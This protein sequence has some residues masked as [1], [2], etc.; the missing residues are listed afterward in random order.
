MTESGALVL[1]TTSFPLLGDGSEAA[2]SFVS[3][4]AEALAEHV[5]VRV[6]CPG[7]TNCRESWSDGVEVFRFAAPAAPMSSLVPWNP[8]DMYRIGRVLRAGQQAVDQAVD[9]GPTRQILALWALPS[10]FWARNTARRT[11]IPYS[12]WT[13]GSDVWSLGRLPLVRRVLRRVLRDA[14]RCY[15]DGFE[16]AEATRAIAGREVAFLP[17]TRNIVQERTEPLRNA[18]PYRLLY[19]GRWH[20]N[21]GIDI[22]LEALESLRDEDWTLIESVAIFGGGELDAQVHRRAA[23]LRVMGRPVNVG[24]YL[25]KAQAESALIGSDYLLIPSR[26]ESIPV[27]LSDALKTRC[28]VVSMPVG[29]LP[30]LMSKGIGVVSTRVNADA[31]A[32]ATRSALA[33]TCP[34]ELSANLDRVARE[35][36]I[37]DEIVPAILRSTGK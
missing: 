8:R 14:D 17:S 22:L 37:P 2:G 6:V 28:A 31:F 32:T 34:A 15:S 21:K 7:P 25:S 4:L 9:A 13:L 35:F 27:V 12:A 1:V 33:R 26:V 3:D 23:A 16:L 29:D 19:L 18:P 30:R 5:P 10:G 11:G 24:G 20:P 36:S